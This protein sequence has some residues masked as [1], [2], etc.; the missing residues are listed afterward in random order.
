MNKATESDKA[1]WQGMDKAIDEADRLITDC[2]TEPVWPKYNKER[3]IEDNTSV[4]G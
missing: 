3:T 4:P 2:R 1:R